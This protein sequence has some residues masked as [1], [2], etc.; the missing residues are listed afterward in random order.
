MRNIKDKQHTEREHKK[1]DDSFD[2]S[3]R[4]QD[5]RRRQNFLFFGRDELPDERRNYKQQQDEKQAEHDRQQDERQAKSNS[6]YELIDERIAERNENPGKTMF[7][8]EIL[9]DEHDNSIIDSQ[10]LI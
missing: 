7:G 5:E 9:Y 1:R 6:Y 10:L 2:R 3:M 4:K 8:D